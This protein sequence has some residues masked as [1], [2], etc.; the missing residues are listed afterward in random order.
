[1]RMPSP[2]TKFQARSRSGR[3]PTE[4]VPLHGRRVAVHL[5][6]AARRALSQ[7]AELLTV[8]LE[9][10]FSCLIRTRVRF[11]AADDAEAAEAGD[12]P[13][14]DGR[15]RL[16]FRPVMSRHCGLEEGHQ[17]TGFPLAEPGSFVPH[18]VR[19]D[20]HPGTGWTGEFGYATG[21]PE[22]GAA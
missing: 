4:T 20:Y 19:L 22:E 14:A 5:S 1:M 8:E 10:F 18:W 7:R 3:E 9:L 12:A 11:P 15:L 2:I 13:A 16:R 17:L 6:P 21:Y